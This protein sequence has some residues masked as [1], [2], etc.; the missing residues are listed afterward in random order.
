MRCEWNESLRQTL[1]RAEARFRQLNHSTIH[2]TSTDQ[3]PSE[4]SLALREYLRQRRAA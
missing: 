3:A 4:L 2:S 1:G